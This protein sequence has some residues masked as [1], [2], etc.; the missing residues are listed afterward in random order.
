MPDESEVTITGA[1]TI[2]EVRV[3]ATTARATSFEPATEAAM[4]SSPLA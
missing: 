4:L 2:T 1:N 3:A